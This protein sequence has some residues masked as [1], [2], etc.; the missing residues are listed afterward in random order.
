M[1]DLASIPLPELRSAPRSVKV[2]EVFWHKGSDGVQL[3]CRVWRGESGAPVVLYLHGIEGHGQW[4]ENSASALNEKGITVYAPDRRGS[5]MNSR[6]RGHLS[7]YELYL[8]DI[9]QMLG[10]IMVDHPG[11]PLVVWGHCWGAKAAVIACRKFAITSRD[12]EGESWREF[13]ISGLVLSCPALYTKIDFDIKTKL[14][15]AFNHLMGDRR[16][17]RKFDIP[18]KSTMFTD[19]PTYIGYLEK[20]PMRLKEATCTFFYQSHLLSNLARKSASKLHLPI[21]ILQGGSD[22]IVDI[23]SVEKW[24][25]RTSSTEKSMR[26]FPEAHHS[27]EFDETWFKEYIHLASGWVL[28][29]SPVVM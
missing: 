2:P 19:N 25:A 23:P 11:H 27:I 20:D 15:I 16:A 6:D 28:A 26:I 5:G 7:N 18:V 4:F 10:R 14:T 29:R 22:Q 3:G 9:Y 1:K 24:L 8:D 13:P 17:L 12:K 21:M